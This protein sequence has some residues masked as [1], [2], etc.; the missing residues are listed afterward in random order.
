MLS[1]TISK[2]D[3]NSLPTCQFQGEIIVVDTP[4][5]MLVAEKILKGKKA[6]GID[7]ETRPAFSKGTH[8]QMALLQVSTER[9]ALLFRLQKAPLSKNIINILEDQNVLKI[10]AA[11]KDDLRGMQKIIGK[12]TPRG[13]VDL[14]TIIEQWGVDERSVRKMSA[15]VL[16]TKVSKAQRLSNWEATNLTAGQQTYAAIDAWVCLEIYNKLQNIPKIKKQTEKQPEKQ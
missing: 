6:L 10:G 14:Q 2:E 1:P 12:F 11:L 16:G 9:H 5:M 8:Y 15:I 4:E 13:F 3:T 7:T